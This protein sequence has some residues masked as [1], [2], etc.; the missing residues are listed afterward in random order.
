MTENRSNTRKRPGDQDIPSLVHFSEA[1]TPKARDIFREMIEQRETIGIQRYGETLHSFN[2]R[3]CTQDLKEELVDAFQYA[4]QAE[5][6]LKQTTKLLDTAAKFIAFF[7]VQCNKCLGKG[8]PVISRI[9]AI[10]GAEI[11]C[12]YSRVPCNF[13]YEMRKF[14]LD[15]NLYTF[16]DYYCV[17]EDQFCDE[18]KNM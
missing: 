13:C 10:T 1:V 14:L 18:T 6:E 3:D 4:I 8:F 5:L 17:K 2:G 15:W 16:P 12:G 7:C 9:D 11:V